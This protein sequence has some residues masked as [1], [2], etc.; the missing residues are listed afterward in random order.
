MGK[1]ELALLMNT[2]L[3]LTDTQP[4]RLLGCYGSEWSATPNLDRLA[5]EGVR[6]DRAY[7]PCPLCTPARGAIFTGQ[8]PGTNGAWANE[9]TPGTAIPQ[10]GTVA[11]GL[12]MRAGYTGKW[13]LDGAGYHGGGKADG[14]FEPDWW[15]DGHCYLEEVGRERHRSFVQAIEG[16]V[17]AADGW[18]AEKAQRVRGHDP[19]KALREAGCREE[20]VWG[21]RVVDRAIDFLE[22]VGS[23]PFVLVVSL[24][25]P[26]GP[27]VTPPEFQEMFGDRQI[28]AP[29]NYRASLEGKPSLQQRQAEEFPLP[30]W[31][32]FLEWRLRH[33]RCNAYV[34]YEIGRVVEAVERL[35][36]DSTAIVATSDHGDQMGSHG[37]LS[38][39][40][41]MYEESTRVPFIAKMPG[42]AKGHVCAQPVSLID[43]FPT[44]LDLAGETVPSTLAGSSLAPLFREPDAATSEERAVSIQFNRF[45]I[46]HEGYGAFYPIRCI[47]NNRYKLAIN[48]LDDRDELYDL[49]ED[50]HETRNLIDEPGLAE[51]RAN[52][53]DCI[54]EE[55]HRTSDPFRSPQW[56]LRPWRQ[57]RPRK[58]FYGLEG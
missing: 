7:T 12:G 45:G 37:L 23:E 24:D 43:L 5:A 1:D 48:L 46:F 22:Q 36:G 39:G 32:D 40:A 3:I 31:E 42:G 10:M 17:S 6:F 55:M 33:V 56:G 54:L 47:T 18:T 52:L 34:D 27:F 4:T 30:G 21:H 53:H 2:V 9:M 38:K 19:A 13:H 49:R 11:R 58:W 25:E 44:V 16:G 15:Y 57:V 20:L 28:P 50:P 14:G 41:M 35:H 51:V 8:V 29:E 26:H